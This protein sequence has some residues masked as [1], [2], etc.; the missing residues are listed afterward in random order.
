MKTRFKLTAGFL[1]ISVAILAVAAVIITQSARENEERNLIRFVGEQSAKDAGVV[2]GAVSRIALGES[3]N[4]TAIGA[5]S[6]SSHGIDGLG[7]GAFLQNSNIVEL[8]LYATDNSLLWSSTEGASQ[9]VSRY[10]DMFQEAVAGEVATD[11][12]TDVQ[13]VSFEGELTTGDVTTTYVPLLDLA[14]H[15]TVQV[16]AVK[17][18][19]TSN[20]G[21]RI[22]S[23]RSTMFQTTFSTLGG[24]LAILLGVVLTAD[25]LLHRSRRRAI[26]NERAVNEGKLVANSLELENQQLRQMNEE[27]DRFLSMV[28]HE[29]RT[30]LTTMIGFSDVLRKRQAGEKKESNI[31]HLDLMRKNGEHLNSLIEDMLEITRIQADKFDVVKEGFALEQFLEQ[32]E[33]TGNMILAS[34]RQT[35]SIEGDRS[36]IEL[37]GDRKR[38][39]QVLINLIS[40]ASKYSPEDGAITLT[41][42]LAG[43]SL[44]LV[45]K[46]QGA[47][48]PEKD[49][50]RLF[51]HFYRMDNVETR[52]QKGLG[53]GLSIVKA[54]VD[55]HH[56][57]VDVNSVVGAGTEMRVSLPGARYINAHPVAM[58]IPA[59]TEFELLSARRDLRAVPN[60]ASAGAA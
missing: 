10:N 14:S 45:V 13:F 28:S 23:A 48:I 21:D 58:S 52:S 20:L 8:S 18:D 36:G 33:E 25:I 4:G 54:I 11:L 34:R 30:P 60:T 53:L 5:P 9:G 24:A 38:V 51:E 12:S 47:G 49:C 55:A 2:A 50:K 59:G 3:V 1:V 40:N 26:D 22:S 16:L 41:V 42:G 31:R 6:E 37:H 17:R 39:L 7:I 57:S 32:I 35:L 19:V 43:D 15:E 44:E 46:D 56:G 27:R 29:L